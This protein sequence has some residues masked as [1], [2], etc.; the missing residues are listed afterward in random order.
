L[1]A[2]GQVF[3]SSH[4]AMIRPATPADASAIATLFHR[5]VRLVNSR[6]YLPAQ[7]AA[8]AGPAPDP[9]KWRGRQATRLTLVDETGGILRGFGELR[10]GGHIDA[11]YVSADHQRQG[12]GAALLRR[13]ETEAKARG[14]R[15]LT[16]EA[17]VTAVSFFLAHGWRVEAEQEVRRQGETL[18]NFRMIKP[19]GAARAFSIDL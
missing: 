19:L 12:V 5:T 3:I 17:S 6:D 2:C 8:W 9:E 16:T 18:R 11:F 13:I 1:T 15:Q 10:P 14:A 4:D 7:V